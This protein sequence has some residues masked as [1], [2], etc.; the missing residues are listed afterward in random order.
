MVVEAAVLLAGLGL[1]V[2]FAHMRALL[3]RNRRASAEL[4]KRFPTI[5]GGP[6]L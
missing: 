4:R 5:H 6:R 3:D 2:F 1:C